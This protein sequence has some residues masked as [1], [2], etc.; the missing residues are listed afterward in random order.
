MSFLSR[1]IGRVPF[2]DDAMREALE[3][4]TRGEEEAVRDALEELCRYRY[5]EALRQLDAVIHEAHMW[6]QRGYSVNAAYVADKALD[7]RNT[8]VKAGGEEL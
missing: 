8:L 1:A 2:P 6:A 4:E 3:R 5:R 7:V